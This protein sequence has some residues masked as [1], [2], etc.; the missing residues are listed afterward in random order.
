[1]DET[2]FKEFLEHKNYTL[3]SVSSRMSRARQS[4]KRL[5]YNLDEAVASEEKMRDSLIKLRDHDTPNQNYQNATRSYY[6]FRNGKAFSKL[7]E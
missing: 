1:M 4:E 6:E 5:G 3:K 2:R 7:D